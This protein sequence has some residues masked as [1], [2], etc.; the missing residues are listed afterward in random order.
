[1]TTEFVPMY[2]LED[3]NE[4]QRQDYVKS[5]C[6]HLGVPDN[7]NLVRL[8]YYDEGDGPRRLVCYAKRG[9]TEIIRDR[10]G[11][12]VIGLDSKEVGGSIVFTATG[13][14]KDGRQEMSTGSKYIKDLM[15]RPLDDAIMTAQT[16]AVRRMTLQFTGTGILDESEVNPNETVETKNTT[17]SVV[18]PTPTVAPAA[19]PGK[20]VTPKTEKFVPPKWQD[21]TL[22]KEEQQKLFETDQAQ[23]RADAIAALNS[24]FKANEESK[25]PD[26]DS[27]VQTPPPVAADIATA[28]IA[29]RRRGRK[30]KNHVDLG[31]SQVPAAVAMPGPDAPE[32]LPAKQSTSTAKLPPLPAAPP[33]QVMPGAVPSVLAIQ[34]EAQVKEEKTGSSPTL[35]LAAPARARLTPE[36]IKPYRQR[37]F[38]FVTELEQAGFAPKEGMGN[39]DKMRAFANIMFLDVTNFNELTEQQWGNY[40]GGLEAKLKAEG[41]AATGKYIEDSIGI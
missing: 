31:P 28:P 16:R 39:H 32:N 18:P 6:R 3:M 35:P 21:E 19:E 40:L 11:I 38:K 24:K 26:A 23:M 2:G 17:Q 34:N 25:K 20:D 22:P 41:P 9:A 37:L 30:P 1:M 27:Q 15:G 12:N 14:N 13:R 7:L 4:A 29:P 5:V 36:Q 8:T 33:Q 10:L